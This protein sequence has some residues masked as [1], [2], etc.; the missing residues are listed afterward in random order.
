MS[1]YAWQY[2]YNMGTC[3]IVHYRNR[4]GSGNELRGNKLIDLEACL[5]L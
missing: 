5:G 2:T 3:V 4:V 1:E